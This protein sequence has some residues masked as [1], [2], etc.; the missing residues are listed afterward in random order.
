VTPR[1]GVKNAAIQE[2]AIREVFLWTVSTAECFNPLG[3]TRTRYLERAAEIRTDAARLRKGR[4]HRRFT[5]LANKLTAAAAAYEEADRIQR[6]SRARPVEA[7]NDIATL[8]KE[9]FGST[10]LSLTATLASVALD[11]KITRSKVREWS[12]RNRPAKKR[13]KHPLGQK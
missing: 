5:A 11:L 12:G 10:K 7:V 2:T 3:E 6:L 8:M 1:S 13:T 9:R 4:P